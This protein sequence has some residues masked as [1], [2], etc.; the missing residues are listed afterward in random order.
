MKFFVFFLLVLCGKVL[1]A[2][3][4]IP[5]RVAAQPWKDTL[6]NHRAVVAVLQATDA[7]Y[8]T[9]PW[10][11]KDTGAANKCLI[12]TDPAGNR[13]KNIYRIR[14]T[15]ERGSFVFQPTCGAGTYYVYYLPWKGRINSGWFDGNYLKAE[16]KPEASWVAKHRLAAHRPAGS[17]PRATVLFLESRTAFDSFYPMEVAATRK[18]KANLLKTHAQ[19]LLLFPEDRQYP[20]RMTHDLPYKWIR[21]GPSTTFSG[22]AL[23]NEYYV[24]Q[25]GLYAARKDIKNIRVCYNNAPFPITCFNLEGVD[26]RGHFFTKKV[27][28]TKG[29]VQPLWF[30][31]DVPLHAPAGNYT[32][33][34]E[35]Q[36]HDTPPQHVRIQMKVGQE[37]LKDR[38]DSAPWRHSR[39]RWLNSTLGIADHNIAPYKP[40]QQDYKTISATSAVVTLTEAGLP[41]S[42]KVGGNELLQQ[43]L[44][45]KI[46]TNQGIA[47]LKMSG[48]RFT[49][50]VAGKLAWE[51]TASNEALQL[52][53]S[54]T[55][56]ADGYLNYKLH[57]KPLK[58]LVI[59]DAWLEVPV[60]KAKAK[61]FMGM[62]MGGGKC[63]TVYHWKWKDPQDAWWLGDTDGGIYCELRGAAY[64]G[65]LLNL[66]RPAPPPA[67]YNTGKGGFTV[68]SNLTAVIC[69]SYTG[70]R[71]L[72]AGTSLNFEFSLLITPVK[73]INTYDQFT[74]RYYHN[75]QK[76][77]PSD[78]D[79][80]AG[81]R[82]IN[83][84]HAN[85]VNPYINYPFTSADTI[86]KFTGSWHQ[87]GIM[88]KL[89]Y[90]IRELTNQASELWALRS[91]GHEIIAGGNGGGYLWLQEHLG[92]DYSAQWFTPVG[93]YDRYDAALLTSGDSRWYNYYIEG[94]RWLLLQTD[95]STL[96]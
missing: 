41:Q 54:G 58:N 92:S 78:T 33:Y 51:S 88:V 70:A 76:P 93:G 30:G 40:L 19:T 42:I 21:Q 46:R 87:K 7:V 31:V 43:P 35:V 28:L 44:S 60:L 83:L 49:K 71:T 56:E 14:I 67:W 52:S 37:V 20:I 94:V 29:S 38:G 84:H 32:F 91:L 73:T 10:R 80:N 72:Q 64:N 3:E 96:R 95:I 12:I 5:Y 59:K 86:K 90:T 13:V 82:I 79:V 24:F 18:E 25:I 36:A 8:V 2:S 68:T 9:I 34:V 47:L 4:I 6:G 17:L 16:P 85:A 55:M 22:I 53:V 75:A 23:K 27:N 45:F 1:S 69:K 61:Y 89:Y 39:L 65:P 66:Y 77:A 48:V 62:G 15:R 26:S 57:I 11:R 81:I 50:Q 63:P 74:N